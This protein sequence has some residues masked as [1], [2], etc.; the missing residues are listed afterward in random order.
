MPRARILDWA[1]RLRRDQ[2][3]TSAV[4]FA[5][6]GSALVVLSLGI[7]EFGRALFLRN[8]LS[9]AA[10][11]AVRLVMLNPTSS[12]TTISTGTKARFDGQQSLLNVSVSAA[13]MTG[14]GMKARTITLTYPLTLI[15]PFLSHNSLTLTV[16]R[17][18]QVP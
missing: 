18:V 1:R 11:V 4:E 17:R 8:D 9:Y 7:M 13:A 14:G 12:Q 10:D 6:V 15:V 2:R 5:L 16:I 3:G